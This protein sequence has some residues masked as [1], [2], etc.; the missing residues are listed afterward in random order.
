MN[1]KRFQTKIPKKA[2]IPIGFV[3]AMLIG[4]V[5]A[6]SAMATQDMPPE[7]ECDCYIEIIGTPELNKPFEVILTWTP[8]TEVNMSRD[9]PD[10]VRLM[11]GYENMLY[12]SGDT[13][14]IGDL[15]KD[16]TYSM[17]AIYA[18]VDYGYCRVEAMISSSRAK[19]I[20][21]VPPGSIEYGIHAEKHCRSNRLFLADPNKD[22]TTSYK[23]DMKWFYTESGDSVGIGEV[24]SRPN[25]PFGAT[26]VVADT[27]DLAQAKKKPNLGGPIPTDTADYNISR[28]TIIGQHSIA[29]KSGKAFR[30]YFPKGAKNIEIDSGCVVNFEKIREN[31][32]IIDRPKKECTLTI[33][34][35][36]SLYQL[37]VEIVR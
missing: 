34:L 32:V 24:T 29:L 3:W 9:I 2:K 22:T 20:V 13:L 27:L 7:F 1:Q 28:S 31:I 30:I 5:F 10:T 6:V 25:I 14:W 8:R 23:A 17:K 11:D 26:A 16:E 12:I 15:K 33:V 18:I 37:P 4:V 36:N 21:A 35:D 19:G